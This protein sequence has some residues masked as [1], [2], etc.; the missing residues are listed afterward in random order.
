MAKQPPSLADQCPP[1]GDLTSRAEELNQR[2][3]E[4]LQRTKKKREPEVGSAM[5]SGLLLFGLEGASWSVMEPL[6]A[7][8]LLPNILRLLDKGFQTPLMATHPANRDSVWSSLL[9]GVEP[10]VHG[11]YA[12]S[13]FDE[14][15]TEAARESLDWIETYDLFRVLGRRGWET[16]GYAVPMTKSPYFPKRKVRREDRFLNRCLR[17]GRDIPT[18]LRRHHR[19]AEPF[20]AFEMLRR[21]LFRWETARVSAMMAAVE[22]QPTTFTMCCFRLVRDCQKYFWKFQDPE[23][24]DYSEEGEK[25]FGDVIHEAYRFLDMAIGAIL[26]VA[27]QPEI[28]QITEIV[29]GLGYG[30]CYRVFELN[31][32]LEDQ[33]YLC[34]RRM[35]GWGWGRISVNHL[36]GKIGAPWFAGS[37]PR[38]CR[39][40]NILWPQR[41]LRRGRREIDWSRTK[42]YAKNSG[43]RL[44]L[45]GREPMGIVES[46]EEQ[47]ELLLTIANQLTKE[48]LESQKGAVKI[49][50][51]ESQRG[52]RG[53]RGHLAPDLTFRIKGM[54]GEIRESHEPGPWWYKPEW[55]DVSGTAR[56]VGVFCISGP[57]V[58]SVK[59]SPMAR[60]VDVLPTLVAAA[61]EF[62]PR[63]VQGQILQGSIRFDARDNQRMASQYLVEDDLYLEIR[64]AR[65]G[66]SQS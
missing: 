13:I 27:Y 35:T 17:P 50:V 46:P 48:P 29:S 62:N 11:I 15:P 23:H 45:K 47:E 58:T 37:I 12:D 5:Q 19:D 65:L 3:Q 42:A 54:T 21:E 7:L 24:E 6:L 39:G 55:N 28:S 52:H 38:Q 53:I 26:R 36:L 63:Y 43:I 57:A 66:K 60:A 10:S 31:R 30:P 1:G 18:L 34:Y 32:W 44:N 51:E 4:R 8:G 56:R 33:G 20:H 9:T 41:R 40:W 2:L 16:S 61:S 14:F 49:T 64:N 59:S 22:S 25:R